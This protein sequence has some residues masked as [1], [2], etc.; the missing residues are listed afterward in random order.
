MSRPR[1]GVL[2]CPGGGLRAPV[3]GL[4]DPAAAAAGAVGPLVGAQVQHVRV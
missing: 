1:L 3:A 4:A 2:I